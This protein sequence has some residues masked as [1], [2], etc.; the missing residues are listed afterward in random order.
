[1][2]LHAALARAV[3]MGLL[4]RN[5][6]DAVSPPRYQRHQWQSLSEFGVSS[7]LEAARGTPYYVLFY[8]ALFTGM[9]R[10]ELLA[11]RWCDVDLLLGRVQVARSLHRLGTGE[12]VI[13][14]PKSERSRR[15]VSLPPS[16]ALLF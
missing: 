12:V 11:L 7:V 6:A 16:A 5:V 14:S 9:R 15:V 10:S 4:V 1:M 2:A 8:Q 13:R 3:K